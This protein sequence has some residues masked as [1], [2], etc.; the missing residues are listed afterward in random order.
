MTKSTRVLGRVEGWSE[1]VVGGRF[2]EELGCF[3]QLVSTVGK[4]GRWPRN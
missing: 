2:G 3:G 1:R 4:M